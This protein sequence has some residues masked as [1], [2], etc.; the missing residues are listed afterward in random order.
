MVSILNPSWNTI[1]LTCFNAYP[2][3]YLFPSSIFL[4]SIKVNLNTESRTT[5]SISIPLVLSRSV[6][7]WWPSQMMRRNAAEDVMRCVKL[8]RFYSPTSSME[9]VTRSTTTSPLSTDISSVRPPLDCLLQTRTRRSGDPSWHT[10]WWWYY[11]TMQISLPW[12]FL[13]P[14][15]AGLGKLKFQEKEIINLLLL[16]RWSGIC[17]LLVASWWQGWGGRSYVSQCPCPELGNNKCRWP[18][19]CHK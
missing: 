3:F 19:T 9:R 10:V 11:N 15:I 13:L 2:Q 1:L 17:N 6:V 14:L 8:A 7:I 18:E 16:F 12:H 4:E 5:I